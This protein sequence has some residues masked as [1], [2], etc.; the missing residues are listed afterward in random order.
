MNS[1]QFAQHLIEPAAQHLPAMILLD[2]I[3]SGFRH[4]PAH[5]RRHFR[6]P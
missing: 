1:N 2:P 5:A 6:H 3:A 4:A